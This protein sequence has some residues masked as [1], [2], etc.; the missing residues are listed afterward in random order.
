MGNAMSLIRFPGG[1]KT[2]TAVSGQCINSL[3]TKAAYEQ[4]EY[5][6]CK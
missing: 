2:E 6:I 3:A 1:F 4:G 5:L